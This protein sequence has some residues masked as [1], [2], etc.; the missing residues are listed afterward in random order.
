M[1]VDGNPVWATA[2]DLTK[3]PTGKKKKESE[4]EK[5]SVKPGDKSAR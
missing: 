2:W 3:K 5:P 4:S 1:K